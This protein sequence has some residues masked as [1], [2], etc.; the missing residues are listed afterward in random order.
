MESQQAKPLPQ[1]RSLTGSPSHPSAG[2][3]QRCVIIQKDQHGFGFTVSGDRVVLVQSVR[4]GKGGCTEGV[5]ES[6]GSPH[7]LRAASLLKTRQKGV[8]HPKRG[9]FG[10]FRRDMVAGGRK[11][12][13]VKLP[14]TTV[15]SPLL[16]QPG[17][18]LPTGGWGIPLCSPR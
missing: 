17:E 7:P 16:L 18:P 14:K 12:V 3:V 10:V 15:V 13:L 2:L 5:G 6:R 1:A 9:W 8:F 4:P 11:A